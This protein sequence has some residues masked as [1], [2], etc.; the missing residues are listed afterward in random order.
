[1]RRFRLFVALTLTLPLLSCVRTTDRPDWLTQAEIRLLQT[2]AE[3]GDA[4]VV[5]IE[6]AEGHR[7]LHTRSRPVAPDSPGLDLLLTQMQTAARRQG[8]TGL[9]AVQVGIPARAAIL[10]RRDE[11]GAERWQAFLD[12]VI[13]S[14]S[15]RPVVSWERCLSVRWGYRYTER[16]SR[17]L[18]RYRDPSGQTRI[19]T[20]QDDEAAVFQQETDHLDGVLLSDGLTRDRFV[21]EAEMGR[22]F[23]Q[24]RLDCRELEEAACNALMKSRWESRAREIR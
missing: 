22:F 18:V 17:I 11:S 2:R 3:R 12:P 9:A 6:T 8:G 13:L 24:M 7:L 5:S 21:P 4:S 10:R 20:L 1:M 23:A 19:E 16:P 15:G 14:R